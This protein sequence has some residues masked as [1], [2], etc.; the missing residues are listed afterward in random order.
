MQ[1]IRRRLGTE[2]HEGRKLTQGPRARW[3]CT[4]TEEKQILAWARRHFRTS[5]A[6]VRLRAAI[7]SADSLAPAPRDLANRPRRRRVN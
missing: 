3:G 2:L 4:P 1:T 5:E 6:E 7:S